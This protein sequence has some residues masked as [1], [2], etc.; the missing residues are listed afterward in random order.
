ELRKF[1]R[2]TGFPPLPHSQADQ[3]DLSTDQQ[4]NLA[5]VGSVPHGGIQQVR[6]HWMLELI[7]TVGGKPQYNFTKL[8]QLI[9]LL[10]VNGLHPFELMGSVSN[11]FT[12]LE[13]KAQVVE[14]RNLVYLLA[15]RYIER[16]GLETVSQWN[17]ETWNEPNNH[18]FDNVSMSVQFLN[19][20][21]A[22]SE[23]LR[24]ASPLLRFGGP[25]DSCHSPPRSPYCW[26]ML[27]H[28]YNG[29]N[30]FTGETGVRLD[31][32]AL[33]K[34]VSSDQVIKQHQ[35]LLADP[36]S[37][38]NYTLLSNDNAFLSYHPHPFTQR[39]LTARFQVNNTQPPHVQ[40]LRKPVLSVM[41]L[42]ALL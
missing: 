19:Y 22:C 39:T 11:S 33:H 17:F 18:D 30:Y 5:Y 35:D 20:Y 4:L 7:S 6:I 31:Y 21:D 38:V 37:T 42:L 26:A 14:W 9:N 13:D 1:W 15:K 27:Q 29:T 36:N 8:D 32:I 3:F 24:A 12:D 41:G 34:K 16:Y 25:G 10:S 28:C 2:S 23:G 40:L